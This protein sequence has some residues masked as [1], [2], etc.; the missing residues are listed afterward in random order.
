MSQI[1]GKMEYKLIK[2]FK[3]SIGG[4]FRDATFLTLNEPTGVHAKNMRRLASY[5]NNVIM[6]MSTKHSEMMNNEERVTQVQKN[7]M[8]QKEEKFISDSENLSDMLVAAFAMTG[9]ADL[10]EAFVDEFGKA[11]CKIQE[12]L[13]LI[14][15]HDEAPF[16]AAHWEKMY[17]RDQTKLAMNYAAFFGIGYLA[18]LKEK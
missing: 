6:Q 10:E 4:E 17:Y 14:D 5:V 16:M 7:A 18:D 12:K 9:N 13:C 1:D 15:D 8:D 3:Y 11:I 2:P